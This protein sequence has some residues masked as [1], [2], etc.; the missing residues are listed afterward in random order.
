MQGKFEFATD[1]T[2]KFAN[3]LKDTQKNKESDTS[4]V[5]HSQGGLIHSEGVRC[6]FNGPGKG[7][8]DI[9]N[10]FHKAGQAIILTVK[11]IKNYLP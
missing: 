5:A 8:R 1:V 2:N 10:V 6:I 3:L 4:W 7:R 9:Q 11:T